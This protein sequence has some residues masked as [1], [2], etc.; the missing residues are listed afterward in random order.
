[1]E[2]KYDGRLLLDTT[3]WTSRKR[4]IR[5]KAQKEVSKERKTLL[6][7]SVTTKP[8]QDIIYDFIDK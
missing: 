4:H 3:E 1:M 7:G 8:V 6:Q 5:G 2:C